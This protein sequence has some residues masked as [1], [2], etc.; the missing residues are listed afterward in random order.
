M[1]HKILP[2]LLG[3]IAAGGSLAA[4]EPIAAWSLDASDG[5]TFPNSQN[6]THP[7]TV[8]DDV[9][10]SQS[11]FIDGAAMFDGTGDYL[12]ASSLASSLDGA[13]A[14][15]LSAWVKADQAGA[16]RDIFFT[17]TPQG[18]DNRLGLRYD[19]QGWGGG[20]SNLLKA[21]IST[22]EGIQAIETVSFVQTTEWQHIALVWS[23]GTDLAIYING[24]KVDLSYSSGPAVGGSITDVSEFFVGRGAKDKHWLGAIDAVQVYDQA[25]DAAAVAELADPTITLY[26]ETFPMRGGTTFR[27]PMSDDFGWQSWRR[28]VR[29]N[30]Q[31]AEHGTRVTGSSNLNP[32]NSLPLLNAAEGV[33]DGAIYTSNTSNRILHFTE[34]YQ[35]MDISQIETFQFSVS[36]RPGMPIAATVKI[37]DQWY[38]ASEPYVVQAD[39]LLDVFTGPDAFETVSFQIQDIGWTDLLVYDSGLIKLGSTGNHALPGEGVVTAFGVTTGKNASNKF[40][41]DDFKVTGKHAP[42]SGTFEVD[43]PAYS[44]TSPA[45]IEGS[46]Q[47]AHVPALSVNAASIDP[48]VLSSQFWYANVPLSASS[49]SEVLLSSGEES[50]TAEIAWQDV[51]AADV[52][53]EVTIRRGDSLLLTFPEDASSVEMLGDCDGYTGISIDLANGLTQPI[54]FAEAGYYQVIL[55][56]DAGLPEPGLSITVIGVEG[57]TGRA[58]EFAFTRQLPEPQAYPEGANEQVVLFTPSAGRI[59]DLQETETPDVYNY[60]PLK[61]GELP[62]A[63]RLGEN[64][65][66]IQSEWIEVFDLRSTAEQILGV[67]E[68]FED[69]TLLVGATMKLIPHVDAINCRVSVI[70][71][72]ITNDDST[73]EKDYFSRS[74]LITY[75]A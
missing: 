11:G 63:M 57:V 68:R 55:N 20:G 49:S 66:I 26:A 47:V 27:R 44:I 38:A 69:G 23:A 37:D 45:F 17:S 35:G 58:C 75:S 4:V 74:G 19:R 8:I 54:L 34:E 39:G 28:Y 9:V 32:V 13:T 40:V 31:A 5:I 33:Q 15:T 71:A 62:V 48:V 59:A 12:S 22:T 36:A 21:S 67:K 3:V 65:P 73:L 18:S 41:I 2:T 42:Q 29:P 25:L 10:A 52:N 46:K 56:G 61:R 14:V 72:G 1:R 16:D 70:A 6:G 50:K 64:G 43:V 30:A 53:Q 51:N 7:L 24:V 60:T